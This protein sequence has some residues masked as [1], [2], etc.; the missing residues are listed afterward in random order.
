MKRIKS[1]PEWAVTNCTLHGFL[2]IEQTYP[3]GKTRHGKNRRRCKQCRY[4]NALKYRKRNKNKYL[5]QTRKYDMHS[6]RRNYMR[7]R[8]RLLKQFGLT[9]EQYDEMHK[10]QDAKCKIC[11]RSETRINNERG[12][13]CKLSVDHCH[14]TGKVRG[15]LCFNCNAALGM[16]KESIPI[17]EEM[18]KYL[19]FYADQSDTSE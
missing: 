13:I 2:S 10:N 9:L 5:S 16:V 11:K 4:K 18:I 7:E 3:S 1:W 17:L 12:K 14:K 15:L 19:N 8:R 6:P